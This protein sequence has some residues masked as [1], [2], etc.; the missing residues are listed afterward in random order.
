MKKRCFENYKFNLC[1]NYCYKLGIE[2][3]F[4]DCVFELHFML[5][6]F[7]TLLALWNPSE[8]INSK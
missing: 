1:N 5:M 2:F 4:Y 8:A 3:F 7:Y 6:F